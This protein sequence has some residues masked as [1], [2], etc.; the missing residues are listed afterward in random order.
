M[1]I[2][3]Y[4]CGECGHGFESLVL[5]QDE[6]VNCPKCDSKK[7][8]RQL[9]CFSVSGGGLSSLDSGPASGGCGSGGFS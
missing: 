2:Y 1:P 4:K 3:E 6:A 5:R 9:S 8:K 7:T